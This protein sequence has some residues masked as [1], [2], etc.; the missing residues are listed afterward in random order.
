MSDSPKSPQPRAPSASR[1]FSF[2]P[3]DFGA[4]EPVKRTEPAERAAEGGDDAGA[5]PAS[6]RQPDAAPKGGVGLVKTHARLQAEADAHKV[7]R[8]EEHTIL[9]AVPPPAQVNKGE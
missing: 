6:T 1:P 5:A 8:K 4:P 7:A 9:M 3:Q 2:R